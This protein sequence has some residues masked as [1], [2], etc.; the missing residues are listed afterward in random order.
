MTTEQGLC[1]TCGGARDLA[2]DP[3]CRECGRTFGLKRVVVIAAGLK[4]PIAAMAATR[5]DAIR[6]IFREYRRTNN[7]GYGAD[8]PWSEFE[9]AISLETWEL[10]D[11]RGKVQE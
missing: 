6:A 5:E 8:V 2:G 10:E 4:Y 11:G 9:D 7:S 3:V 1:G